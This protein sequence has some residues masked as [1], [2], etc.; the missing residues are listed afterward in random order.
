M[1]TFTD[2]PVPDTCQVQELSSFL[3]EIIFSSKR[4]SKQYQVILFTWRLLK[5]ISFKNLFTK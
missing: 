1:E 5:I 3:K 4:L 2:V